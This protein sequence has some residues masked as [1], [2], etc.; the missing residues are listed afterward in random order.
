MRTEHS[1]KAMNWKSTILAALAAGLLTGFA[2]QA[3]AQSGGTLNIRVNA[4]I[5]DTEGLNRDANTD[6]I[7]HHI[8]ETLVGFR[9]D[10]TVGPVLAESWETSEDGKT[11]TFKLRE[12]ATFHN[13]D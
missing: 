4:D 2:A 1:E 9:D 8:F 3:Q 5:R 13:G 10:L 12:G 11:Y 6:T 7:L